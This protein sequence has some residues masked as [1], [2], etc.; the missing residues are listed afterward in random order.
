MRILVTLLMIAYLVGVGVALAPTIKTN[1]STV[2]ASQFAGSISDELPGA[3]SWPATAYRSIGDHPAD[4]EK[5][6][7]PAKPSATQ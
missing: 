1:W 5:T 4:P 3:L 7:A 6:N 2:P